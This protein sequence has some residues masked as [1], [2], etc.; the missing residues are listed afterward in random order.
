MSG[1]CD[2]GELIGR[3]A[4]V[5]RL[6]DLL[7]KSRVVLVYGVEGVGKTTLVLAAC[8]EAAREGR[9]PQ[10][11]HVPLGGVVDPKEALKR[12]RRALGEPLESVPPSKVESAFV[13]LLARVP[14]TVIWDDVDERSSELAATVRRFAEENGPSRVVVVSRR[15]I[16]SREARLQ[17]AAFEVQPLALEAA[18]QLVEHLEQLRGRTLAEDLAASTGCKPAL[19]RAAMADRDASGSV[20]AAGDEDAGTVQRVLERAKG[21]SRRVLALLAVADAMLVESDVVSA[22]GRGARDAVEDLRKQLV[23]VGAG[24]RIGLSAAF[25]RH[26]ARV[27]GPPDETV[28]AALAK[29]AESALAASPGA[30]DML[31]LAMRAEVERGAPDAALEVASRHPLARASAPIGDLE[32]LLRTIAARAPRHA[33]AALLVL[34]RELVR[35]GDFEAAKR[36]L[37]EMPRAPSAKLVEAIAILRAE[38]HLRGGEPEAAARILFEVSCDAKQKSPAVRL[39]QASLAVF[40]GDLVAAR[41]ELEAVAPLVARSPVLEARRASLLATSY[42]CEERYDVTLAW[43]LRARAA[44]AAEGTPVSPLVTIIETYAR[45]GLGEIDRADE[46]ISREARGRPDGQALEVALFVRRGDF[47]RAVDSSDAAL[48]ALE[49]RGDLLLRCLLTRDIVRACSGLG[50]LSRAARALR[51]AEAGVDDPGLAVLRPVCDLEDAR[52][53][54]AEGELARARKCA[55]RAYTLSPRSPIVAIERAVLDGHAPELGGDVPEAIRAYADLRT[56]EVSLRTGDPDGSLA[57]ATAAERFYTASRLDHEL[58]RARLAR[59]EA[60]ARMARSAVADASADL[61]ARADQAIAA[62]ESV[63]L[64][65]RY[66]P[67]LVAASLVRAALAEDRGD[68]AGAARAIEA[69]VR[70]AGDEVGSALARAAARV[71]LSAQ[72]MRGDA[73]HRPYAARI[74]RLGLDRDADVAWTVTDRTW[75]RAAGQPAPVEIAGYVDLD[76]RCLV[77]GNVT[78]ELPEQRLAL[79]RLLAESGATGVTLE[80]IFERVWG[81]TFH[82]LRH[83]NA[84]Y[85]ALTRLK[86]TLRP[87]AA[88]MRLTHESDRYRLEGDRP[89]GVRRRT[90]LVSVGSDPSR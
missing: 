89:V 77:S 37:D 88:E 8:R 78:I 47:V 58:A 10:P 76:G 15:F 5:A 27:L 51:L 34:A 6:C 28:A 44:H 65:R 62:C 43:V 63:A 86:E 35:A 4:D 75:L 29:V 36:V 73:P 60:L 7:A 21:A 31:L 22:L 74:A 16:T 82:P 23:V 45:L 52:L 50:L 55:E 59:G 67:I 61:R 33:S 72:V 14:R 19:I 83:R 85:V 48:A 46:L 1:G 18:V 41:E 39:A 57:P 30:G 56:A 49:Q 64:A 90:P 69:A 9:I 24:E 54:E 3:K 68:L 87:V 42:F 26:A 66:R 38:C 53:A 79:L 81:G 70:H 17:T 12:T 2:D 25:A 13:A 84:V 40:R 11:V 32:R 80:D 20:R 71:G